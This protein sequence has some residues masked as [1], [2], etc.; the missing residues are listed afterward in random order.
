VR[1]NLPALVTRIVGLTEGLIPVV[2]EMRVT[3]FRTARSV[4]IYEAKDFSCDLFDPEAQV[5]AQSE[6]IGAHVVPL[7]WSVKYAME[8]FAGDLAPGDVVVLNDPCRGGAHLNDVTLIYPVFVD[9][10][11]IFFPNVREHWADVGGAVPGSLSG[12]ASEIYQEGVRIPPIKLV[13]R[14]QVNKAAVDL[15]LSNMRVPDERLGDF[16]SGMAACRTAEK[17]IHELVE[18]CG[19]DTLLDCVRINLARSEIR[20]REQIARLPD[21]EYY[22]EDYQETFGDSGR[23][24]SAAV[25]AT[26][27]DPRHR[28]CR[29]FHRRRAAG[30]GQLDPGGD[31]CLG[32]DHSE[33][34][35]RSERADQP[36]LVPSD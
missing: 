13:A 14:D 35:A 30:A 31:R 12:T 2:R 19:T 24:R 3:V 28:S 16:H 10:R 26:A 21:G 18:R 1:G 27:G 32:A 8:D 22:Y 20:T 34:G 33:I 9:G 17:R 23:P 7:P 5:I 25:A 15:I 11:L 6:D 36:R 29:R 4:A